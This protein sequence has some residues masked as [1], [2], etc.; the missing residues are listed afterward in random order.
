VVGQFEFTG[1]VAYRMFKECVGLASQKTILRQ[2]KLNDT[3][4][5]RGKT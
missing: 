2:F 5:P 3:T 4:E 1:F